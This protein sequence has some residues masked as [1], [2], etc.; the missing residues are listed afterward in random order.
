MGPN[1]YK[2]YSTSEDD[3]QSQGEEKFDRNKIE[4]NDDSLDGSATEISA[5]KD[6]ETDEDSRNQ[7]MLDAAIVRQ[8]HIIS[9]R[10]NVRFVWDVII[11]FFAILNGVTLP[12]EIAFGEQFS[13]ELSYQI[14]DYITTGIFVL[15]VVAGF[16]TSYVNIS[17]G[18]EIFGMRMI[19][20]NY[21]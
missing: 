15:D 8:P 4:K 6:E 14:A 5:V 2:G 10:S 9:A 3:E 7:K 20:I 13:N 18:D 1:A 19:A 17:S 16:F 21:I 11:I 12:L